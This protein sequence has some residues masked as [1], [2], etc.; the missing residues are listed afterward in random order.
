[1][2]LSNNQKIKIYCLI[3]FAKIIYFV[4]ILGS[5]P[6]LLLKSSARG[7]IYSVVFISILSGIAIN[8]NWSKYFDTSKIFGFYA[9][10]R[11][12]VLGASTSKTFEVLPHLV[13]SEDFPEVSSKSI[14]AIEYNTGK[15]LYENNKDE[16]LPPAS[17]TKLMTALVALDLYKTSEIVTVPSFCTNLDTQKAGYL[18]GETDNVDNLLKTLLI[19]SSGDAA[20][21]LGVGKVTYTDFV[22]LMNKKALSLGMNNTHFTN[23]V[24][25]DA[26][27][28][29]NYS[30]ADD[31]TKLAKEVLKHILLK[32]NVGTREIT[33]KSPTTRNSR[34]IRST[35][36]LLWNLP[37][38]VG[39]KT[40]R[41]YAAG[42]VL[43]YE[44]RAEGKDIIIVVMGSLDRFTDTKKVLEW[45]LLSY[46]WL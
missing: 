45:I 38:T 41:T 24:G 15:I 42:E 31:L 32:E 8:L 35:N 1:M 43:I 14:L 13:K 30:S 37:G 23:P 44:Y 36:D 3:V 20:C 12:L 19:Y 16:K 40:G 39:I 2:N 6:A 25:L 9:S 22:D 26:E 10:S 17:T 33:L 27:N 28:G 7:L 46:S 34:Q 21:A 18:S 5:L 11:P 4:E 29:D